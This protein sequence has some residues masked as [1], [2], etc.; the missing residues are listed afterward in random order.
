MFR[1]PV[2]GYISWTSQLQWLFF[3]PAN[4]LI[5]ALVGHPATTS[6]GVVQ[7]VYVLITIESPPQ[8]RGNNIKD[9]EVEVTIGTTQAPVI[10]YLIGYVRINF[11]NVSSLNGMSL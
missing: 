9:T 5:L 6:C 3:L 11:N 8:A 4:N 1:R 10:D 7:A 2:V